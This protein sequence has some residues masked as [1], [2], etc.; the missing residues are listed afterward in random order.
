MAE[1]KEETKIVWDTWIF[2]DARK[3]PK[4]ESGVTLR[5]ERWDHMFLPSNVPAFLPSPSP[6][7]ALST[8]ASMQGQMIPPTPE[9]PVSEFVKTS[10]ETKGD[11]ETQRK[12]DAWAFNDALIP[13]QPEFGVAMHVEQGFMKRNVPDELSFDKLRFD[14]SDE[15]ELSRRMAEV[16]RISKKRQKEIRKAGIP[17]DIARCFANIALANP[18]KLMTYGKLEITHVVAHKEIDYKLD[19]PDGSGNHPTSKKMHAVLCCERSKGLVTVRI[20]CLPHDNDPTCMI[21]RFQNGKLN[22]FDMILSGGQ[23]ISNK[24]HGNSKTQ[25]DATVKTICELLA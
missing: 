14:L 3:A 15:D 8:S 10:P 6:S 16:V 4:P 2:E 25:H 9:H 19:L 12:W 23:T 18:Y 22:S 11:P 20:A 1:E 5:R 7:V 17:E 13:R 21:W 24:R